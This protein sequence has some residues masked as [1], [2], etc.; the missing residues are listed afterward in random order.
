MSHVENHFWNDASPLREVH[1]EVHISQGGLN[2]LS[3]CMQVSNPDLVRHD[4]CFVLL[5]SL[6]AASIV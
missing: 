1:D 6:R 3:A 5:P 2:Q 4:A